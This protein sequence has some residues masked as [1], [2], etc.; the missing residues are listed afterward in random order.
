MDDKQNVTNMNI[1]EGDEV[2][3]L[4]SSESTFS[5]LDAEAADKTGSLTEVNSTGEETST[6]ETKLSLADVSLNLSPKE[7]SVENCVQLGFK[8]GLSTAV[9]VCSRCSLE[10]HQPKPLHTLLQPFQEIHALPDVSKSFTSTRSQDHLKTST[11]HTEADG[12][13]I[14]AA[15]LLG[16]LFCR[17]LDCL[18]ETFRGCTMCLWSLCSSLCGCESVA[19]QPLLDLTQSCNPCA[20][21]SAR[22]FLCDC[23]TCDICLPATECLDLAMEISQMLYH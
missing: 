3:K 16:C 1:C 15:I 9:Y 22:C 23:T 18:L 20:F 21:Q 7:N 5:E 14:C 12:S 10:G 13:D 6:E 2:P 11:A 17:P 4:Q 19:L 8:G